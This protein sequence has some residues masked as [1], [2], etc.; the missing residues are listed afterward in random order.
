[1]TRLPL[2]VVVVNFNGYAD[3][4][5]C[6]E[7]LLAADP[8]PAQVVVVDNASAD[9][10]ASTLSRWIGSAGNSAAVRVALLAAET[11]RGFAAACNLGIST[12]ET[13]DG[14]QHF[15]LLNNDATV[16]SDF[17]AELS[18]ALE[19]EPDA[20]LVGPTIYDA[21]SRGHVWYAGGVFLPLRALV[22]HRY[23]VPQREVAVPT[24]F[25]S[26]CAML[27]SRRA[28]AVLGPLPE[29]YF[30]YLEDAEYSHRALA[31]GLR[32]VYAPGAVAYHAVG[33][34]VARSVRLPQLAYWVTRSRGLFVRRNLQGWRRRCALLYLIV[35]KPGRA[36][37]ETLA[38]APALGWA[39]LHGTIAG[40]L[41]KDGDLNTRQAGAVQ[42]AEDGVVA[43]Q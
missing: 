7:S 15:L 1:M 24:E 41:S 38:G 30:M 40:L 17:F 2:S 33:A 29:C 42:G 9:G 35:T 25:V 27:V 11:N 6:L 21:R 19:A 20:A 16:R 31:A 39:I 5:A 32:V 10:S 14:I 18:R 23:H 36:L 34:S 26:G 43:H 8:G 13:G 37:V 4:V 28:R 3:T 12:L 22:A